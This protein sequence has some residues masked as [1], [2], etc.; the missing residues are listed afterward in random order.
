MPIMV[1]SFLAYAWTA[2]EKVNIAGLI[3]SLFF[4][5]L[6]LMYVGQ[7][8]HGLTCRIIYSATLAYLV[9]ANP[10]R[11]ASAIACNS[12]VRGSFA[13]ILSQTALPIQNAI[14]DGGLFTMFAGLLAFSSAG[15]T[16]IACK[17]RNAGAQSASSHAR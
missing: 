7:I 17:S 11:S 4:A 12:F 8:E 16:L 2:G 6:S 10:G 13:C 14:G 5:G 9:D 3:V 1:G 15:M